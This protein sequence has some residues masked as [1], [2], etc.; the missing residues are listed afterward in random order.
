MYYSASIFSALGYR[1]ATAVGLL[2][3]MVNFGFTIIA[4]QASTHLQ[5]HCPADGQIVD[6]FGR[7]RTMLYTIPIMA[8][9]LLSASVFFHRKSN[10]TSPGRKRKS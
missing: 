4:L 6:P 3:A 8:V 7:R 1:N 5:P 9:A 2:I 10:Q